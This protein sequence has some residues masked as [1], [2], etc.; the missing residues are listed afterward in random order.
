MPEK[1]SH[2]CQSD[3]CRLG[4]R[5]GGPQTGSGCAHEEIN[6]CPRPTRIWPIASRC[7][8]LHRFQLLP[9][10]KLVSRNTS[11]KSV[12]HLGKVPGAYDCAV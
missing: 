8:E 10:A 1:W 12:V 2:S 9:L 11:V 4:S 7:T 5:L 3:L 6:L